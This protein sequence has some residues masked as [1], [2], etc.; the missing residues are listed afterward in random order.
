[1]A[2][3][4]LRFTRGAVFYSIS[5]LVITFKNKWTA[6]CALAVFFNNS[7]LPPF[8]I[9]GLVTAQL[10][11]VGLLVIVLYARPDGISDFMTSRVITGNN[12]EALARVDDHEEMSPQITAFTDFVSRAAHVDEQLHAI[13]AHAPKGLMRVF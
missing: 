1:M 8:N 13:K 6:I 3:T 9:P 2:L 5:G 12:I 11:A 7:I 10:Q 4:K